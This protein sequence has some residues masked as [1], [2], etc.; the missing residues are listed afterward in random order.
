MYM[1]VKMTR[2]LNIREK[3]MSTKEMVKRRKVCRGMCVCV[4]VCMCVCMCVCV[5][6]DVCMYMYVD[7]CVYVYTH[8][9]THTCTHMHAWAYAHTCMQRVKCIYAWVIQILKHFG[10][11]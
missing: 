10:S 3:S 4:S 6:V 11:D 8:T 7:V 1:C 2:Y 5:Y 9:H